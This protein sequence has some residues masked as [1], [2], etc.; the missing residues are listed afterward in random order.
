MHV[1]GTT[2]TRYTT[3]GTT[4][5]APT[6]TS[7]EK[8]PFTIFKGRK[9][10]L[11]ELGPYNDC[12]E[13]MT[14]FNDNYFCNNWSFEEDGRQITQKNNNEPAT[15]LLNDEAVQGVDF[16]GTMKVA[17]NSDSDWIGVTFGYQNSNEFLVLLAPGSKSPNRKDHWRLTKVSSISGVKNKDMSNAITYSEVSVEGQTKVL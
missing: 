7:N 16:N 5:T 1:K 3:P 6:T 15:T 17:S 11:I 10:N 4:N 8:C 14:C 9:E 13:D 2:S 12:C